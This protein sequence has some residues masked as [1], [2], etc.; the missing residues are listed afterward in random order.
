MLGIL[1]RSG[2]CFAALSMTGSGCR[3]DRESSLALCGVH[4][5]ES[6]DEF[7]RLRTSTVMAEYHRA[8]HEP[9]PLHVWQDVIDRYPEMRFWVAYNKT[10]PIEMLETLAR[11]ADWRVRHMVAEKRKLPEHLQLLLAHDSH[12]SVRARITYNAKATRR[13]LELLKNDP[14]EPARVRAQERL[15]RGDFVSP[16]PGGDQTEP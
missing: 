6:A 15:A 2:R 16:P 13:A 4:V 11:D 8:A 10:V 5:L 3:A 12:E 1:G 14:W 9:A 7:Y